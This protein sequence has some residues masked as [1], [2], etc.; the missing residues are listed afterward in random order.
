MPR[1]DKYSNTNEKLKRTKLARE[2]LQ[3]EQERAAWTKQC[4]PKYPGTP[5]WQLRQ[6]DYYKELLQDLDSAKYQTLIFDLRSLIV[7]Q[8]VKRKAAKKRAELNEAKI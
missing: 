3:L 1:N 2:H 8:K 4:R 7:A 6:N 5:D